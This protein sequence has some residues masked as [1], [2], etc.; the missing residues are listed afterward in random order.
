MEALL[1]YAYWKSVMLR[2]VGGHARVVADALV[3][4]RVNSECEL[5]SDGN[6]NRYCEEGAAHSLSALRLADQI[7]LIESGRLVPYLELT[8]QP[9]LFERLASRQLK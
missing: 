9:V 6:R 5:R 7:Y 4:L 8:S 1:D 2:H 3:G